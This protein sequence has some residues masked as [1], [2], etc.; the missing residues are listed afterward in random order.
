MC[1]T[2]IHVEILVPGAI[3]GHSRGILERRQNVQIP[4]NKWIAGHDSIPE[5]RGHT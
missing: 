5:H 2:S 1:P 3:L 4:R